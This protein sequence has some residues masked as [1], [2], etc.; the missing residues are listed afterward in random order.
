MPADLQ[1]LQELHGF[2]AASMPMLGWML[3][4]E[5]APHEN[6]F[7]PDTF[8]SFSAWEREGQQAA[9]VFVAGGALIGIDVFL[10]PP[11]PMSSCQA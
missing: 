5:D 9:I 4:K 1:R 8:G 11:E 10:C 6:P 7:L 3:V 2:Y